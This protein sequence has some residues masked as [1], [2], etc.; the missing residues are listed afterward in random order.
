MQ[1]CKIKN[2]HDNTTG[3]FIEETNVMTNTQGSSSVSGEAIFFG[4]DAVREGITIPENVRIDLP[5]DF[6][7]D[8]AIAWYYLGGF[9]KTWDFGDDAEGH[10]WYMNKL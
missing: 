1:M 2:L 6:G 10:I 9:V 8:Q 5:K 3:R 4:A 7:R